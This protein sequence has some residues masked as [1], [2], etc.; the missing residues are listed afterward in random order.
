VHPVVRSHPETGRKAL[1]VNGGH[2]VRF[3]DMSEAESAPLLNYLFAHQPLPLAKGLARLLGQSLRPA[4]P[5]Q[6][7]PRLSPRY[8]PR[9]LSWR[10]D[11]LRSQAQAAVTLKSALI[12]LRV[13]AH[14]VNL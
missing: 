5:D 4:Q 2:T 7:L 9:N 10:Q 6:R 14:S 12:R 1:Y 8:A 11:A 13:R 3:K